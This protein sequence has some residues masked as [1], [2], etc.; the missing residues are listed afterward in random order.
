MPVKLSAGCSRDGFTRKESHESFPSY[1]T[2]LVAVV[3]DG[4]AYHTLTMTCKLDSA[5]G[6]IQPLSRHPGIASHISL[7]NYLGFV[8]AAVRPCLA[9]L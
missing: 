5:Q 6:P 3:A 7:H 9:H 4:Y 1:R 2:R 8:K